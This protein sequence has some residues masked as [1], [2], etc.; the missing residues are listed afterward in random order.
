L[1]SPDL[2]IVLKHF[3]A[4]EAEYQASGIAMAEFRL[5]A[6][7]AFMSHTRFRAEFSQPS[8]VIQ[9]ESSLARRR[10]VLALDAPGVELIPC[11]GVERKPKINATQQKPAIWMALFFPLAFPASIEC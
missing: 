3:D 6:L 5:G 10:R 9:V 11:E 2:Q 4:Y 8:E 7:H 1:Q